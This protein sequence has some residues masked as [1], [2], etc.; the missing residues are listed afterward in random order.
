MSRLNKSMNCPTVTDTY[1][2]YQRIS[3]II[4]TKSLFCYT[5]TRYYNYALFFSKLLTMD[6]EANLNFGY[7]ILNGYK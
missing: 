4:C 1:V 6:P 3:I 7:K 2:L 5:L